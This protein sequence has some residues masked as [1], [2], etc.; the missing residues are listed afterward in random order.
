VAEHLPARTARTLVRG[1]TALS[2]VVVFTA[3]TPGQGGAHHI[4]LRPSSFWSSL[5]DD[6]GFAPSGLAGHLR[7]AIDGI[8][9]PAWWIRENLTVFE[10]RSPGGP[11][12]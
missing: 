6:E 5:F 10:R 7:S 8:D 4:N 12:R 2:D 3:A 1:L 9:S 11:S